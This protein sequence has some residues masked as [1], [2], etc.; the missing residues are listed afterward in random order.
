MDH[1]AFVHDM[2]L[3]DERAPV[4]VAA[5]WLGAVT[6]RLGWDVDKARGHGLRLAVVCCCYHCVLKGFDRLILSWPR[7]DWNCAETQD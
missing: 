7:M 6:A 4:W 2:M 3:C 1:R 5:A